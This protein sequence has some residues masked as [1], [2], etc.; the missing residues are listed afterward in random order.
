MPTYLQL[1]RLAS[2]QSSMSSFFIGAGSPHLVGGQAPQKQ[3]SLQ[4]LIEAATAA[5]GEGERKRNSGSGL[6]SKIGRSL[7]GSRGN[8]RGA[9]ARASADSGRSSNASATGADAAAARS[10]GSYTA[11]P[12]CAG[13]GSRVAPEDAV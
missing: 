10:A 9:T 4:T 11:G 3:G 13:G 1:E 8:S 12:G 7:T 5:S 6:L 2:T